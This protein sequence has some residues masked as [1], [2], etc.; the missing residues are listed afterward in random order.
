MPAAIRKEEKIPSNNLNR[1]VLIRLDLIK[2]SV[3]IRL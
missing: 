3:K 1:D 2:W